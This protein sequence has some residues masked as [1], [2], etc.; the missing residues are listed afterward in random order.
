VGVWG[1]G[2]HV[3]SVRSKVLDVGEC[4]CECVRGGVEQEWWVGWMVWGGLVMIQ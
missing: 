4:V 1:G 3:E 2:L